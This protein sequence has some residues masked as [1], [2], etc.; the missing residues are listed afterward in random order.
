MI[1]GVYA[2]R[3]KLSGFTAPTVEHNDSIALRNFRF[4]CDNDDLLYYSNPLDY[5]LY[6]IGEYDTKTG[7][8]SA[9]DLPVYIANGMC[10][11]HLRGADEEDYRHG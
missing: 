11:D 10:A 2:V 5:E 3:D 7:H 4:A 9:F 1:L 6:K 8:I